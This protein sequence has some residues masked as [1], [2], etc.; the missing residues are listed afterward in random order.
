MAPAAVKT[1]PVAKSRPKSKP[2]EQR[3]TKSKATADPTSAASDSP[4]EAVS[5][6]PLQS[7]ENPTRRVERESPHKESGGV[8]IGFDG[9]DGSDDSDADRPEDL[10]FGTLD[11]DNETWNI[12]HEK[13][14][15]N[16]ITPDDGAGSCWLRVDNVSNV[17][18]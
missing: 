1:T 2:K 12:E 3:R 16:S 15:R 7:A 9:I 14:D 5:P 10:G 8:A 18:A 17:S 6:V 4:G 11:N 13:P